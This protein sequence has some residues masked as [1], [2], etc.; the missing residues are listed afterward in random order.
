MLLSC[1]VARELRFVVAS[2]AV[3][4]NHQQQLTNLLFSNVRY[5]TLKCVQQNLAP[6]HG[7]S[8]SSGSGVVSRSAVHRCAA[9][10]IHIAVEPPPRCSPPMVLLQHAPWARHWRHAATPGLL[11]VARALGSPHCRSAHRPR[12]SAKYSQPQRSQRL[13]LSP[14]LHSRVNSENG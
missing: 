12:R 6:H 4:R 8:C 1:V 5:K 10:V 2:A 3:E 13:V 14:S 7:G 11:L 9:A